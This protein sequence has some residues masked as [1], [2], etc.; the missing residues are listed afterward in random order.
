VAEASASP[1]ARAWAAYAE[2]E[3]E[4]E[5]DPERSR[6]QLAEAVRRAEEAD[7]SLL[8]GTALLSL[9]SLR[10]RDDRVT[11]LDEELDEF[12]GLINHWQMLGMWAHQWA[13]LRNLVETLARTG[14]EIDAARLSGATSGPQAPVA[15]F[16]AEARRL[17]A[18]LRA[19]SHRLGTKRFEELRA[20]GSALSPNDAV[21]MAIAAARRRR[22]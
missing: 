12:A 18:A 5:D 7:T 20:E 22:S 9:V 3:I 1:L 8:R 10:C 17:N 13:T 6:R 11:T 14:Q 15:A 4:L 19:L 21:A 2:G 16:G